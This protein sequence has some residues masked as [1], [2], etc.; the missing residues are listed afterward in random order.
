M[1]ITFYYPN[2]Q[3]SSTATCDVGNINHRFSR[4]NTFIPDY[5]SLRQI[6]DEEIQRITGTDI[7][8]LHS[9]SG[10]KPATKLW[11]E[12]MLNN[13]DMPQRIGHRIFPHFVLEA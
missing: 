3:S 2:K 11:E 6:G 7:V 13:Y 8:N 10:G 4:T 5:D 1:I 12:M 9:Y